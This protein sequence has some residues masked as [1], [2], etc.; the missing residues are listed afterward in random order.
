MKIREEYKEE[1]NQKQLQYTVN[2]IVLT[3]RIVN[4]RGAKYTLN[5]AYIKANELLD[6]LLELFLEK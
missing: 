6:Q 4:E 1:I 3:K 5:Q 2:R